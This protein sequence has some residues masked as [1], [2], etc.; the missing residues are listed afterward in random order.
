MSAESHAKPASIEKIVIAS[1]LC[2]AAA[3]QTPN[4]SGLQTSTTQPDM[5]PIVS[6]GT[7]TLR[8]VAYVTGGGPQQR[9]DV[10]A[11]VGVRGLPVVMFVHG[12][13][14]HHGDKREVR[15]KPQFLNERGIVFISVN[16]RLMDT[17]THPAQASDVASA[18]RWVHDH[19][20]EFGGD[21]AKIVLMGHSAGCHLVTLVG[22][23]PRWLAGVQMKPSDLAGVVSWS[24]GAFDLVQKVKD[25]G[26]YAGY[27]RRNFGKEEAGW[28]DASPMAHVGDGKPMPRFLFVSA[29]GDRQAS[30]EATQKMVGLIRAAGGQAEFAPLP[31]KDHRSA[32]QDLGKTGDPT[33]G[34]LVR[35]VRDAAGVFEQTGS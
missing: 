23:D 10:Y 22:L 4:A 24:G 14:W 15:Y 5:S 17:A 34:V 26:L 30:K 28:R 27:I 29:E 20:V 7:Q 9:L 16:Y 2:L 13:E 8:D 31:G 6:G 12:G 32:N 18:V 35:F 21:P 1:L 11:P 33:G 19:A 25:G 3:C